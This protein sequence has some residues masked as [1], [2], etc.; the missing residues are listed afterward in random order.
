M[1]LFESLSNFER[2]GSEAELA[3]CFKELAL[4][5]IYGGYINVNNRYRIYIR[6][7]E[8]YFHDE[9]NSPDAIKDPIV[10]KREYSCPTSR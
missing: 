4:H 8:F 6:T 7:V 3:A 1:T 5:F 10:R 9:R 2:P